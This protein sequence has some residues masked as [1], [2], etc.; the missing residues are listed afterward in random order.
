MALIGKLVCTLVSADGMRCQADW[1]TCVTPARC[2]RS[3]LCFWRKFHMTPPPP[4]SQMMP[5]SPPLNTDLI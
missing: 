2:A 4:G 5:L 3:Q 1:P